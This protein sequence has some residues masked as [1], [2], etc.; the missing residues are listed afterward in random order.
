M[1]P[2]SKPWPDNFPDIGWHVTVEEMHLH[3]D[4][5]A[6]KSGDK[7]AAARMVRDLVNPNKAAELARTYH[8]CTLVPVHAEESAGR[9][10]IPVAFANLLANLTGLPLFTDIVQANTRGATG[11]NALYRFAFRARFDGNVPAG[12]RCIL[13]DDLRSMGGTLSDMRNH[14]EDSGAN[15]L[16][17]M[18]LAYDPRRAPDGQVRI[19][20]TPERWRALD[21]KFGLANLSVVLDGLN[22]YSDARALTAGEA[23]YLLDVWPTLDAFRTAVLAQ[24]LDRERGC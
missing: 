17:M 20:S 14:I 13:V 1:V 16:T 2:T 11:Q 9:N 12:M 15:V 7:L 4:Y 19:A 8:N 5:T 3:A 21:Q 10:A 18:T 6:A 24:R 22:I 23:R